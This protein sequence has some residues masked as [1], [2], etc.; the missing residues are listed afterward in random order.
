MWNVGK[1]LNI[2]E[3]QINIHPPFLHYDSKTPHLPNRFI[4]VVNYQPTNKQ[5]I[6]IKKSSSLS[7]NFSSPLFRFSRCDMLYHVFRILH[8]SSMYCLPNKHSIG[9]K[10]SISVEIFPCWNVCLL[11]NTWGPCENSKSTETHHYTETTLTFFSFSLLSLKRDVIC[12]NWLKFVKILRNC[13]Q[14][15]V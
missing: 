12:A 14:E 5:I 13:E 4:K 6:F 7:C 15:Y 2:N 9:E 8:R 10:F 1:I 11:N 3:I